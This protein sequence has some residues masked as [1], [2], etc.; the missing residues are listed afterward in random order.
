M[1]YQAQEGRKGEGQA[2]EEITYSFLSLFARKL[3][4]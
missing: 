4:L 2:Q 3:L 1:R